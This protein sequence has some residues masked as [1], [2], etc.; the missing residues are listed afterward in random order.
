MEIPK[1]TPFLFRCDTHFAALEGD[2]KLVHPSGRATAVWVFDLS[3]MRCPEDTGEVHCVETW[4]I[5]A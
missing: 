3:D 5:R 4:E 1:N 2:A